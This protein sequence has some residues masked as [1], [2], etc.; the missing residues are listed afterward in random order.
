M[1]RTHTVAKTVHYKL[2]TKKSGIDYQAKAVEREFK[3]EIKLVWRSHTN[4]MWTALVLLMQPIT[5]HGCVLRRAEN[6]R[7][8][9]CFNTIDRRST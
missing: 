5:Q 7:A 4:L 9:G 2:S 3:M 8:K 1:C 6:I